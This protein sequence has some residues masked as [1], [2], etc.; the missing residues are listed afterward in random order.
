MAKHEVRE[1]HPTIGDVDI[2]VRIGNPQRVVNG[3]IGRLDASNAAVLM[4]M[5]IGVNF[6]LVMVF[7][8]IIV[9]L[10]TAVYG[11]VGHPRMQGD[12]FEAVHRSVGFAYL[13]PRDLT[14]R[15]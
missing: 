13:C 9:P 3:H 11:V 1:R 12:I 14:H 5:E 8:V 10:D 15:E 2:V 4:R 6:G 7:Q